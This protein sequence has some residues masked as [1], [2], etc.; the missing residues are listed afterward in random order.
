VSADKDGKADP[1]ARGGKPAAK[2]VVGVPALLP[3]AVPPDTPSDLALT[4]ERRPNAPADSSEPSTAIDMKAISK[5]EADRVLAWT[6]FTQE[7]IPTAHTGTTPQPMKSPLVAGAVPKPQSPSS[8][9]GKT[10]PPSSEMFRG[11]PRSSAGPRGGAIEK[12]TRPGIAP[13]SGMSPSGRSTL[14]LDSSAPPTGE[15]PE[16]TQ[17][18][19]SIV[20]PGT[21][22]M[23]PKAVTQAPPWG[24]GA[25]HMA[26]GIP[27][28]PSAPR[29]KQD[30][31]EEI[32][33]SMLLPDGTGEVQVSAVE[34][35]SGS[36]LIE[37][38]PDGK[39]PVVKKPPTPSNPPARKPSVKP[40]VPR[41]SKPPPSAHRVLL[42]IPDLPKTTPAPKLD[43]LQ[44]AQA[45]PGASPT[46]T[47]AVVPTT[48]PTAT[49]LPERGAAPAPPPIAPAAEPEAPLPRFP[50]A[51]QQLQ[52]SDAAA[53]VERV[54]IPIPIPEPV[55]DLFPPMT[56]PPPPG[57][58][59]AAT[60]GPPTSTAP[61]AG[62]IGAPAPEPPI[63]PMTGDIELTRLPRQGLQPALDKAI[64]TI[65]RLVARAR[66]AMPAPATVQG[67]LVS[68][69]RPKW[70]LPA[71][72]VAGLVVGVGLVG[73]I[74]SAVRGSGAPAREV[75]SKSTGETGPPGTT[76]R[77]TATAAS[78]GA[79]HVVAPP[80]APAPATAP[81]STVACTV[82]GAPHVIGPS[83]TVTAGVEAVRIGDDLGLGFA[84]SDR[85]AIGVRLDPASLSAIA[86]TKARSRDPV[87]RVTPLAGARGG[88]ALIVDTDRKGDRLQGRRT[89]A[90]EPPLQV[91]AADGHV[92]FARVG[93]GPAGQLWALDDG[94]PVDAL[95]GAS[96]H[97]GTVALTFRRGGAVWMGTASGTTSLAPSGDL[98]HIEGLGT[99][100][101]SPAIAFGSG[102]AMLAWSDRASTDEPWHL[103]WTRFAAGTSPTSSET[104]RPPAGGK[105]EQ[106]MSPGITALPGGRFLL[107]W[108]EGPTS[109][110]DVRALTL[111]VDGKPL[112]VPLV[113]SNPG[114][115]AGQGQAVVASS[116]Q[117]AVAFLE[118]GGN[119]FQVV[120]T[121]IACGQ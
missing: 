31:I 73:L 84:P 117:G 8:P 95:R 14:L 17:D 35:L 4:H 83:A 10:L 67:I 96:D 34:E 97:T 65:R 29:A 5:A 113:I 104:F 78:T 98:A 48:S 13:Q 71:V 18:G 47:A 99:A 112:G 103:R 6:G 60:G 87:K 15:H 56:F 40:P 79:T 90:T 59:N 74:V 109:A 22:A 80:A 55:G 39:A 28:T 91:G 115:N 89:I 69:N 77:A 120:A 38:A 45:T 2:T 76:A 3:A 116:G 12:P 23:P 110:H 118:S 61:V 52:A 85:D 70:F 24:E 26:P 114:V 1:G 33:S 62:P 119:G 27:K 106:A 20:V 11:L 36:V 93:G 49:T 108:T 86:T 75:A 37:D 121:P 101:G 66:E 30:S 58:T 107:V 64:A 41:S 105:G 44:P 50:D 54:P 72:A 42:G 102:V 68:D 46:T 32:S 94:P 19:P 81:P 111:S 25:V 57:E 82:S 21:T 92:S 53:L 43:F 88:L 16:G 7:E 100:V 63:A 51:S 9:P